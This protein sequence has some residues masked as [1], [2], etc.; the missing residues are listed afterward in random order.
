MVHDAQDA[1][2]ESGHASLE[3]VVAG[4]CPT[5]AGEVASAVCQALA[6]ML[7]VGGAALQF[8]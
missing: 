6:S 5:L 1:C 2:G 4:K 3:L 7:D 8:G